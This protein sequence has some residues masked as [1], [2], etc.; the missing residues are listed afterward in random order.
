MIKNLVRLIK[1]QSFVYTPTSQRYF[2]PTMM[3][4]S[5]PQGALYSGS[6]MAKLNYQKEIP[7]KMIGRYIDQPDKGDIA[8]VHAPTEVEIRDARQLHPQSSLHTKGFELRH[9]P[10]D[11]TN[12]ADDDEV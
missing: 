3:F 11:V 10:T 1:P 7:G 8:D 9:F 2:L 5:V 4:G 12:F 6:V